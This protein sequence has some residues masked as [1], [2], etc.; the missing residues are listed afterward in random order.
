[1][2]AHVLGSII[3][4]P[5]PN[6]SAQLRARA[7][8]AIKPV[9]TADLTATGGGFMALVYTMAQ[10]A[11][12]P[13]V[14]VPAAGDQL[15]GR[16]TLSRHSIEVG[17]V[18]SDTEFK[19]SVWNTDYTRAMTVTHLGISDESIALTGPEPTFK[20]Q[21]GASVQYVIKVKAAGKANI[22]DSVRV[23]V[24][25]LG[26]GSPAVSLFGTRLVVFPLAPDWSAGYDEQLTL[27]TS[28]L[29]THSGVEQRAQLREKPVR[30]LTYTV[31]AV[32]D[33]EAGQLE[34]LLWGWQSRIFGVP[35]WADERALTV[36]APAGSTTIYCD[37]SYSEI[38]AGGYVLMWKDSFTCEALQ[39]ASVQ[40]DRVVLA[41]PLADS[42]SAGSKVVPVVFAR[43]DEQAS[44]SHD[45]AAVSAAQLTFTVE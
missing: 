19:L 43:M 24:A 4:L 42:Y 39:V 11:E 17:F 30:T 14:R 15:L 6:A 7:P 8:G 35:V 5:S 40:S 44:T 21:P 45:A 22:A 1:M 33:G 3:T 36:T 41:F 27:T 38:T 37:T 31:A 32:D 26:E 16:V 20:I 25:E 10:A 28:L 34:A 9:Q 23:A 2:P 18:L 29:K 12:K 13:P